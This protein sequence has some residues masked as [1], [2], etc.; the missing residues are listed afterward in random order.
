M[1]EPPYVAALEVLLHALDA[2]GDQHEALI[3]A[4]RAGLSTPMAIT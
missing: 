3:L 4:G 1:I 2:L